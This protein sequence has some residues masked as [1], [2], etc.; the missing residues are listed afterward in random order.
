MNEVVLMK[1][2]SMP[3]LAGAALMV[4][5]VSANAEVSLTDRQEAYRQAVAA[6]GAE[7]D[8]RDLTD[9]QG[10]AWSVLMNV[11][12]H[13]TSSYWSSSSSSYWVPL[14]SGAMSD[15]QFNSSMSYTTVSG[16]TTFGPM[17]TPFYGYNGLCLR[18]SSSAG[19]C[20][21]YGPFDYSV[22]HDNGLATLEETREYAFPAQ[23]FGNLS[24]TRK[25]FVPSADSFARWLT[26]VTNNDA[27]S[28]QVSLIMM[29][30]VG[31]GLSVVTSSD[32]DATAET[33]DQWV[34][35]WHAG[36]PAVARLGHV[37]QGPGASVTP[38]QV[39][40][41]ADFGTGYSTN[42]IYWSYTLTV[43]AGETATIMNFAAPTTSR[44]AA[45]TK[46]AALTALGGYALD[47]MTDEEKCQV[48]NFDAASGL[49]CSS[50]SGFR[51]DFDGD[52]QGDILWRHGASGG[53][54]AWLMDGT[55]VGSGAS[56]TPTGLADANWKIA[57][58]NDF[59]GDGY[60]DILWHHQGNG[61]LYV[62]FM[63]PE[64]E[65]DEGMAL[66]PGAYTAIQDASFLSPS[67]FSDVQW[68]IRATEDFDG[69]GSVDLLW[70]HQVT[71]KLY[72]WYMGSARAD[73]A[74][75]GPPAYLTV[76]TGAYLTPSA[77]PD[78]DW[79]I[80]GCAD[81]NN[82]ERG[83]LL[84]RHRTTGELYVWYLGYVGAG[85][86]AISGPTG[87]S[88]TGGSHLS[89]QRMADTNWQVQQLSDFN[90]DG[91]VD[92]LWRNAATGSL[93]VWYLGQPDLDVGFAEAP[94]T[95]VIGG[96]VLTPEAMTDPNWQVQPR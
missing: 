47:L 70:H 11:N 91:R 87:L 53:L 5:A 38:A 9:S 37:L 36:T 60:Q 3:F 50:G 92:I 4:L 80:E 33:S 46:A 57:G 44:A 90:D 13:W 58:V 24:V 31:T 32:G 88:V 22:F 20:K 83:D 65:V 86:R 12:V 78:T 66:E 29:T 61:S 74:H 39:A 71:G 18:Q 40:F 79:Q 67:S 93:Y 23:T 19:P 56:F 52:G 49:S 75:E 72:V 6:G 89:V 51:G 26:S 2:W 84:W 54:F 76:S 69:N 55:S 64:A 48:V 34:T 28:Q 30:N 15:A 8:V 27:T 16:G 68:Q 41:G 7:A 10:I 17:N 42:Y 43:A 62:W 96:E 59:N 95:T 45:A 73:V 82:D 94:N 81:F 85:D 35:T 63:G 25:V 21:R 77:M 1:R 14:A